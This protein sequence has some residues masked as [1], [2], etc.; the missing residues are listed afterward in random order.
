MSGLSSVIGPEQAA[1][2]VM[3]DDLERIVGMLG[4]RP[5][6]AIEG[7][8][9]AGKSTLAEGLAERLEWPL[10]Q[11]DEFLPDTPDALPPSYLARLDLAA[12]RGTV[13][14]APRA[15]IEGVLL[16]DALGS[17]FQRDQTTVIYIARC[18][19][20]VSNGALLWHDG[21]R[22]ENFETDREESWMLR[23]EVEYHYRVRPHEG[24]DVYVIRIPRE[25][26]P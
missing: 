20:P 16:R 13:A 6:I 7:F 17:L 1:G 2:L 5:Y 18:T 9:Q 23:S 22:I 14:N 19:R 15:V 10:I 4:E 3:I 8:M 12:L 24:A 21:F 26:E 11:L 25:G